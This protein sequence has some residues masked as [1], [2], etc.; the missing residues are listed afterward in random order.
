[1]VTVKSTKPMSN[2]ALQ[3]L[4]EEISIR[5]FMA[6]FR[7][8]ASFNSRLK[9]TGGRYHLASHDL[10]FNPKILVLYDL[11]E[12]IRVIKHELCHYHLHLNQMGYRH[13]DKAFKDLLKKT[14]GSR[15]VQS[16]TEPNKATL[17]YYQC[18]GCHEMIIRKRKIDT[19]KYVCGKCRG[20][21]VERE[22]NQ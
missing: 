7:H 17:H 10:D 22:E 1:M 4:V 11:E 21:L 20:T 15:Y 5:Y 18:T 8:K 12:L 6:P 3:E 14:G 9:T 13:R 19:T 16:L 2:E